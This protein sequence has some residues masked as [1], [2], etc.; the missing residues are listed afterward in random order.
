MKRQGWML[1]ADGAQRQAAVAERREFL[2]PEH[3]HGQLGQRPEQGVQEQLPEVAGDHQ[4]QDDREKHGAAKEGEAWRA[5]FCN[6]RLHL[7]GNLV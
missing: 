7:L 2:Q 4:R 6:D 1:D 5:V 3:V